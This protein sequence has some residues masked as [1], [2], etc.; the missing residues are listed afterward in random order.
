LNR[1]RAIL[2]WRSGLF[3]GDVVE[4]MDTVAGNR[5]D[6]PVFPQEKPDYHALAG[7]GKNPALF[8]LVP[9]IDRTN[10]LP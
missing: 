9:F 8:L 1:G 10:S 7:A 3:P 6:K 5:V 4:K 2:H